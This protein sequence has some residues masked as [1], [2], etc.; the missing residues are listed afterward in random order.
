MT[1]VLWAISPEGRALNLGEVI[2]SR[3]GI[4]QGDDAAADVRAGA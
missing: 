2:S 1:Y 3:Q 4:H